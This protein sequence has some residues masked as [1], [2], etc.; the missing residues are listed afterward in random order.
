MREKT[1]KSKKSPL[2]PS[3]GAMHFDGKVKK[4]LVTGG[5]GYIGSILVRKL[6]DR[7][8]KVVVLDKLLFGKYPIKDLEPNPNFEFI[9]G[10]ILNNRSLV[11]A[12]IGI[13]A[14]V[15]LA[16]IAR[17]S[18]CARHRDI[19]QNTNYLG[20]VYVA[21]ACKKFGIK[22]FIQASTCSV[23]GQIKENMAAKENAKLFP[24]DFYSETKISAE[25]ELMKL[26]DDN[27]IPTI[28]RF[29]TAYGLSPRMRFDLVMN[30]FVKNA[31]QENEITVFGGN[32]WRPLVHVSDVA[33]AICLVL[34]SPFDRVAKQIFNVGANKEN[35]KIADLAVF[36]KELLPDVK[37]KK[38]GNMNDE[39]SYRVDFTKIRKKLGFITRKK[40]K[41]GII[42]LKNSIKITA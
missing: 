30:A 15:N 9:N 19:A 24:V 12:L 18:S 2:L 34:K 22:R 13:D 28:L 40:L 3:V 35:Y 1:N 10:D 20:A 31:L 4:V 26:A 7:G 32:Q 25:K 17:E 41:D 23:Y 11:K 21:L 27:F 37:I 5:A 14:V 42:E 39:R 16:A 36:I 8:Y 33:E 6:L 29:G 38:I